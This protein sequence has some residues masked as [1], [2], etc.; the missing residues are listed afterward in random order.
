MH[1]HEMSGG[2]MSGQ[3]PCV[4]ARLGGTHWV[5]QQ[6]SFGTQ[7]AARWHSTGTEGVGAAETL[8]ATLG[9]TLTAVEG[10]GADALATEAVGNPTVASGVL[11]PGWSH[12]MSTDKHA[13]AQIRIDR[14]YAPTSA[15]TL[16][17]PER[18]ALIAGLCVLVREQ[19]GDLRR[20]H[21]E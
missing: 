4:L 1:S 7:S 13:I 16:L 2:T 5:G 14:I 15:K 11:R 17:L 9:T 20:V 6:T 8:G 21:V 18:D 19:A 3:L 12:A 10:V